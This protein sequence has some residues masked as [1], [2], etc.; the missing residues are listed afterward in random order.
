MN[1][2]KDCNGKH[3]KYITGSL[4]IV[5]SLFALPF[6]L[7]NP[8]ENELFIIISIDGLRPEF[9]LSDTWKTPN[10][11]KCVKDGVYA[12]RAVSV[13]PSV[14]YPAH[15]SIVTGVYPDKHGIYANSNKD[16]EKFFNASSFKSKTLWD[17][18]SEKGL[19]TASIYW[20]TTV[21]AKIDLLVPERWP[22]NDKET[23][24]G[25]LMKHSTKSLL[26]EL[27][28]VIGKPD[29]SK[30]KDPLEADK[31]LTSVSI[32]VISKHSPDLMLIHFLSVDTISHQYGKDSEE[33]KKALESLD[34]AIGKIID[35]LKDRKAT[36][37]IVGDHGFKN[38]S[39]EF[40]PNTLLKQNG[41]A[42]KAFVLSCDAV[43]LVF[44]K[45]KESKE[46]V[47]KLLKEKSGK[48]YKI[49]DDLKPLHTCDEAI[50]ALEPL[51]GYAISDALSEEITGK[52]SMSSQHG[53]LPD[54]DEL[55][56]GF[57]AVG[58]RIKNPC[59]IDKIDLVDIAPTLC[60]LMGIICDV[61]GKA[62]KQVI[63]N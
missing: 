8:K 35:T 37:F 12:K 5:L 23:H 50:A 39:E 10:L 38:V 30:L 26:M 58:H 49:I 22:T 45:D 55:Y 21:G 15:A 27:L 1:L 52:A 46:K 34:E 11:K 40:R 32:H 31:L 28:S 60:K 48:Y 51:N 61:D 3:K 9:Y 36:L 56:T 41:L 47:L 33:L 25:L 13:Y 57:I 63:Q 14:T 16:G 2:V 59:K 20:P 17:Y 42:A 29:E 62:I 4:K 44:L 6:L 54:Q 7:I 53:H 24:I 19:K 43:G 18:A